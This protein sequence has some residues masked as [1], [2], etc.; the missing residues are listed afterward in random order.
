MLC[1]KPPDHQEVF[2]YYSYSKF[3][4]NFQFERSLIK[5]FFL[6]IIIFILSIIIIMIIIN[7]MIIVT[8]IITTLWWWLLL[9]LL[10]LLLL[11]LLL[12]LF[13]NWNKW[14]K[15]YFQLQIEETEKIRL[16][17]SSFFNRLGCSFHC[18]DHVHVQI[19]S[20]VQNMIHFIHMMYISMGRAL[21]INK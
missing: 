16:D 7:I 20:T 8:L 10:S 4:F 14:N 15:S 21:R 2:F 3:V 9:S 17:R 1:W 11:L 19:F 18:E 5:F 13:M 6:I 12:L